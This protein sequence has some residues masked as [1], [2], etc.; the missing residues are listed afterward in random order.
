[1]KKTATM[2]PVTAIFN[3]GR[4]VNREQKDKATT[5]KLKTEN[6]VYSEA[7]HRPGFIHQWLK[8]A[9]ISTDM[10]QLAKK[11][12]QAAKELLIT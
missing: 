3:V 10:N 1:M 7:Y 4:T 2:P 9:S 12:A 11:M 6:K 5:E 8:H